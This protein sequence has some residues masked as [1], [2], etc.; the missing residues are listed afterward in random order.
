MSQSSSD[1]PA[2]L[3]TLPTEIAETI[4][5]TL[6]PATLARLARVSKDIYAAVQSPLYRR[7]ILNSYRKLQLFVATLNKVASW[8]TR[9]GDARSKR[10]VHLTLLIDPAKEELTTGRPLIAVLLARL[11][12]VIARYNPDV[13]ITLAISHSSCESQPVRSFQTE[14]FPRVTSLVLDLGSEST[15]RTQEAPSRGGSSSIDTVIPVRRH[16]AARGYNNTTTGGRCSP[17]AQFWIRFF[18]GRSFPD[19][20]RL[21]LHHRMRG[22]IGSG[23]YEGWEGQSLLFTE[24]DTLGLAKMERLVVNSVPEF[25]DAVLM[26]GLQHAPLLTD[27]QIEDCHVSYSA[28]DK[29]LLHALPVLHRLVLRI[30]NTSRFARHVRQKIGIRN[31]EEENPHLCPHFRRSGKNLKHFELT[32]PFICRDIYLDEYE[33]VRLRE[34]GHPGTLAG[35]ET[36]EIAQGGLDAMLV[37]GI[38]QRLR[39]IRETDSGT[40]VKKTES[41]SL[42]EDR[43]LLEKERV[44]RNRRVT[45]AKEKWTRKLHVLEGICV[46]GDTFEELVVL[47]EVE[48]Q[49]IAWMLGHR[50]GEHAWKVMDGMANELDYYN[51]FESGGRLGGSRRLEHDVND[52][53]MG[54]Q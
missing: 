18:N 9:S 49:G 47:A 39:Q 15:S 32:A 4:Y 35:D 27:L 6:T 17:N 13:T 54:Q 31:L 36:G 19:L 2:S 52:D 44:L 1:P 29:L 41:T 37:T 20:Q 8:D 11:V 46:D 48:E 43:M 5:K 40:Q 25:N 23:S 3:A 16:I 10:I 33:K 22:G 34:S 14:E 53:L 24:I 26:A 28:L 30:P 7:P 50:P 42:E 51:E 45:I 12:R 21:E 38:L